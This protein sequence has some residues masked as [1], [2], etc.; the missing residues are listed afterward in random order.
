M[1]DFL[2]SNNSP[3]TATELDLSFGFDFFSGLDIDPNDEDWFSFSVNTPQQSFDGASLFFSDSLGDLDL[4]LYSASDTTF[5]IDSSTGTSDSEFISFEGLS[6]GDYFLRVYGFLG[7]SNPEY[8]L[9]VFTSVGDFLEPN[10]NPTQATSLNSDLEDGFAF[11]Y[12]LDIT[13]GDEDWFSFSLNTEQE[14]FDGASLFFSHFEG[15]L[16]LELYSASDTTSPIDSSTGVSDSEFIS[17]DGLSSGD[18]LLR[19]YGFGGASNPFYD[20]EVFTS[21]GDDTFNDDPLED[22]DN[23]NEAS[24]LT[25]NFYQNLVITANDSDFYEFTL[26]NFGTGADFVSIDFS[27][28]FGDLDIALYDQ[29][30]FFIDSSTSV[31]DNETISLAGLSPGNYFLEVYGFAGATNPDYDLTIA[32]NDDDDRFEDNDSFNDAALITLDG[33]SATETGLIITSGDDD[34]FRFTLPSGVI[35]GAAAT[36]D[37]LDSQGDLDIALYNSNENFISSSTGVIDQETIALDGLP[38]GDYYLQV[39]GYAGAS[40]PNYDLT[41]TAETG[42]IGDRFEDNDNSGNPTEIRFSATGEAN[43]DNLSIESGDDDWYS[44][45]LAQQ[46]GFGDEVS[47]NFLHSLGD[48]DLELYNANDT[49]FSIDGS[50]SVSDNESISLAFLPAGDYLIR[51][52][53]YLEASNPDYSL[54]IDVPATDLGA[55]EDD[56]YEP[57][58]NQN[59]AT[60]IQD[61]LGQTIDNLSITTEADE[62][63]FEFELIRDGTQSDN[64]TISFVSEEADLDLGLYNSSGV[65][66]NSSLGISDTET[67]SFEGLIPGIYYAQV[68]SYLGTTDYSL[69]V[70]APVS[71]GSLNLDQYEPNDSREDA[72]DLGTVRGTGNVFSNL[73]IHQANNADWFKFSPD[74]AGTV[75]ITLNFDHDLGDIDLRVYNAEGNFLDISESISDTEAITIENA[76]ADS[77]Y[78]VE[79]YGYL[80]AT[81][82]NYSLNI[83]APIPFDPDSID[84]DQYEPNNSFDNAKELRSLNDVL[85][86]LTLHQAGDSDWFKFTT[87]APG[88][89]SDRVAVEFNNN[90]GNL[91]LT[92]YN[93]DGTQIDSS[94]STNANSESISLNGLAPGEYFVEVAGEVNPEYSLILD[95]DGN[96]SLDDWTIMVYINGDNNLESA[97]LDDINEMELVNLPDNVNVVVQIDRI[98]GFDTSEGNWTD[99]RRGLIQSDNNPFSISS[100]LTSIGEQNMGD[101]ATLTEFMQWGAANY[102]ADNYAVVVWDHGGGLAGVSWDD[103]SNHSNL[104]TQELR[105]AI[106]GA[107]LGDS[108]QFVG[109][110]ACLMGLAE[111]GYA[112]SDLSEVFVGSQLVEPGDGWDYTSWLQRLANAGGEMTPEEL[113][114]AVVDSYDQFYETNWT[115]SAVRTSEYENL[116]AKINDFANAVLNTSNVDWDGI[117]QAR[118]FAPEHDW[119]LPNER[120]LRSFMEGVNSFVDNQNQNIKDAANEVIIAIDAAVINQVDGLGYN[121]IGI[122]L[123]SPNSNLRSDYNDSELGF[124]AD[125]A[126]D[127]FVEAIV[128]QSSRNFA[129][130][131]YTENSNLE[132]NRVS[133][134][135]VSSSNPFDLGTLNISTSYPDLSID[136]SEDEDWFRLRL[137]TPG[138]AD[139][140]AEILFS[141]AEGDLNLEIYSI[142]NPSD[143]LPESGANTDTD[144]ET[145]SF[146]GLPEGD[147]LLKVSGEINP[148]YELKL[149]APVT[150]GDNIPQDNF[151]AADN[152]SFGKATSLGALSRNDERVVRGL[153]MDSEDA[154]TQ[155]IDTASPQS[156]EGGDWFV[157]TPTRNSNLNANTVTITFNNEQGNLDLYLFDADGGFIGESTSSDRNAESVSFEEREGDVYVYVTGEANPNYELNIA[158]RTFDIDGDGVA[159]NDDLLLAFLVQ[160]VSS[161]ENLNNFITD[162]DLIGNGATRSSREDL[163]AYTETAENN[164]LDLDGNGEADTNDLLLAFLVQNVSSEENL[165]NFITDFDLIGEDATRNN[166]SAIRNFR[167]NFEPEPLDSTNENDN[168]TGTS[169][170]DILIGGTGNDTLNGGAGNDSLYGGIDDDTLIGG[171]GQDSFFIGQNSGNDTIQDFEPSEDLIILDPRLG[172]SNANDVLAALSDT[173]SGSSLALGN[174]NQLDI[175]HQGELTANNF[176]FL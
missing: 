82:P 151:E 5:P 71:G 145:I 99:T 84:L 148:E 106:D 19:V 54:T 112:V 52:Y 13:S 73:S 77:T 4:E 115:Q 126:W 90:Q 6:S 46:G 27:H 62:D 21:V 78:F 130:S 93:S 47:I 108:L 34:W 61:K 147:Y 53:G 170:D 9:D 31:T 95:A 92:L 124:L 66:I 12:G 72:E 38:A 97:A 152:D 88:T 173:D 55:G 119:Q 150:Q 86:G 24:I 103:T 60:N 91:D 174:D 80:D 85:E 18:Y 33:G 96:T 168:L 8:S 50:F 127:D 154:I 113:A 172:F 176:D 48:L 129:F 107:N 23:F 162:F 142:D 25:P 159:T 67:I 59:N 39:Y 36:I 15:D 56:L 116:K 139:Y 137:D 105:T 143:P 141:H 122:Y 165:N 2:E 29:N 45:S 117:I 120:D 75:D 155:D 153:T 133:G 79:V 111:V 131:D 1:V 51:V 161:E 70:S 109:L 149:N 37:F 76:A 30:Q 132:G 22:N 81:N 63:W 104:D 87:T 121:G 20:L 123:P 64:V 114:S 110:D 42:I 102:A 98:D 40:N 118:N 169:G 136:S 134:F 43:E 140:S 11:R 28:D 74:A 94:A 41:I 164:M 146:E 166:A 163:K 35:P 167:N 128:N 158:R 65:L 3:L 26:S 171:A 156:L 101:G 138:T 32:I 69:A 68:Y 135:A 10:D 14:F 83:D 144:N 44:F 160:N 57:N 49:T 175:S 157:F 89:R 125:N 7:A 16:D 100:N 58:N 17:F